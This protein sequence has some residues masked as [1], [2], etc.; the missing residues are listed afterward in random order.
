VIV[1]SS[2]I[3]APLCYH[4]KLIPS[5]HPRTGENV[6]LNLYTILTV[7]QKFYFDAKVQSNLMRVAELFIL[8]SISGFMYVQISASLLCNIHNTLFIS[9]NRYPILAGV[10][11]NSSVL[12]QAFL[13]PAF[14]IQ[15]SWFE[16]S[17][18]YI[19]AKTFGSDSMP[20]VSFG[21]TLFFLLIFIL[22]FFI[23]NT[24]CII[25]AGVSMHEI[26]LSFMMT[27]INHP[28]V[29]AILVLADVLENCFCLYSLHRMVSSITSNKVVPVG[30]ESDVR[31]STTITTNRKSLTKRT[32]SVYNLV[33]DLDNKSADERRGT[34]LFIAATLLQREL[35]ETIVPIQSFGVISVLYW[36][37]IKSNS[38]VSGMSNV[39]Y[40]Q[41]LVYTCIDLGVELLVFGFTIFALRYIF[42]ELKPLRI[43]SG[44][45]KMHVES[46]SIIICV[47]WLA[48]LFYQSAYSGMDPLFRFDW[49]ACE[50]NANSTWI[51]G[52]EWDC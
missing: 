33:Q 41:A 18:D 15:R 43:L 29:F 42:P 5:K 34:A 17:A 51:G 6:R 39:E 28:L 3:F 25:F 31:D 20:V 27:S 30:S 10:F 7:P 21:G 12:V 19:T 1:L 49:L 50:D 9:M 8:S 22:V 14:F 2:V 48:N 4:I 26:C 44:L 13:V 45:L 23:I 52:Y 11:F 32:S 36:L 37:D 40:H 24:Q 47:A 38:L 16:Y 46:M 35:V